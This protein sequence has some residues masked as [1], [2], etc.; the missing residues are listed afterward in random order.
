MDS[1]FGGLVDYAPKRSFNEIEVGHITVKKKL[2]IAALEQN[3]LSIDLKNIVN[4]LSNVGY[5]PDTQVLSISNQV[6]VDNLNGITAQKLGYL[7]T[8]TSN[9]QDQ[10]NAIVVGVPV[11]DPPI[12]AID[13]N[14]IVAVTGGVSDRL[15]LEF[16]DGTNPGVVSVAPQTFAGAKTFSADLKSSLNIDAKT[17]SITNGTGSAT[18]RV[19][20]SGVVKLDAFGATPIWDVAVPL[21]LR[22]AQAYASNPNTYKAKIGA[23]GNVSFGAATGD[24]APSAQIS[25]ASN[26]AV[27]TITDAGNASATGTITGTNLSGT[28]T[29]D[30]T[31]TNHD[32]LT[33]TGQALVIPAAGAASGGV[34]TTGSQTIAGAKTFNSG[35]ATDG[36]ISLSGNVANFNS[37]GMGRTA[38]EGRLAVAAG[39]GQWSSGSVAGDVTL[40][41][42]DATK[43][44]FLQT[45]AGAPIIA[46]S[47]GVTDV[48]GTIVASSTVKGSAMLSNAY[49]SANNA[50][51]LISTS[52][53]LNRVY[54]G[55]GVAQIGLEG[56]TGFVGVGITVPTEKLDVSG[57]NLRI[58][59]GAS[60]CLLKFKNNVSANP[61]SIKMKASDGSVS[62]VNTG[63]VENFNITNG[64]NATI[65]GTIGASNLS[66]TNTGD[67]T[68]T[69]HD[70]LT[71]TGQA[72]VIPAAGAAS[73]GILTTGVQTIAGDKTFN[74]TFSC[75]QQIISKINSSF[76]FKAHHTGG[77]GAVYFGASA[78]IANAAAQISNVGGNSIL[79]VK[80]LGEVIS[81]GPS[82]GSLSSTTPDGTIALGNGAC[83]A[84]TLASA[85]GSIGIGRNAASLFPGV[86]HGSGDGIVAIGYEAAKSTTNGGC[87]AIGGSAL[88]ANTTGGGNI[89]IGRGAL[90][91][92][93][94]F[95]DNN[96]AIG[97]QCAE[98]LVSSNNNIFIGSQVAN[99]VGVTALNND[100]IIGRGAGT[101]VLNDADQNV[102]I[103]CI[104]AAA[105]T[106]G[107]NNTLLGY[108][109]GSNLTTG[110]SNIGI[111]SGITF[112]SATGSNQ[113]N[114][115]GV[116]T[117]DLSTG[118]ISFTGDANIATGKVYKI[119]GTQITT[120]ALSDVSAGTTSST[121]TFN[122][123]GTP[124]TS[125]SVTL[126]YEKIKSSVVL[127]ISEVTAT[128]G[129]GSTQFTANTALPA[130]FRPPNRT[131][132]YQPVIRNSALTTTSGLI[133]LDS[134]GIVKILRDATGTAWTD[135]ISGGT[136][137]ATAIS[138]LTS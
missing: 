49:N 20:T 117:G 81:I 18:M 90:K 11:I 103:G 80:D 16:A 37:I 69:N 45:G 38:A 8:T 111:G 125:A 100:V 36:V 23:G 17:Y 3:G 9:V 12:A 58:E 21:E 67:V 91:S 6:N 32:N 76:A 113:L 33:L 64:G 13:A 83:N 130:G 138:F 43:K 79:H 44:L 109:A 53:T 46:L 122:G 85:K 30:V 129:T 7:T 82:S 73:G 94:G 72:L 66:G 50:I 135:G 4:R 47:T 127:R 87:I 126:A 120:A 41:N 78:N 31:F 86:N 101:G 51:S 39:A 40:R 63:G 98:N 10:I 102:I 70:N 19:N 54:D 104:A 34:L 65:V 77:V 59:N 26:A 48:T 128:T 42:D 99:A 89:A 131:M 25:N 28:N 97:D 137:G 92:V 68:F 136:D 115:G 93:S 106:S 118:D 27:F 14:G 95:N 56:T 134:D 24:A 74:D 96:I 29:G 5:N 62:I 119:N 107:D 88:R 110:S 116:I 121:F 108:N 35:A 114:I 124:G 1:I 133:Q 71:L 84:I 60:D 22:S 15:K 75:N 132:F 112:A 123:T 2:K 52:G 55:S 105:L 61:I 57:G